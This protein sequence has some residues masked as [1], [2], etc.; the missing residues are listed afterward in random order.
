MLAHDR[1]RGDQHK[2]V[3]DEPPDVVA[4]FVLSPLER[5]GP[6]VEQRWQPKL[7]HWLRPDVE[8]MGL[9]FH[10]YGLPLV[11]AQTGEVAVVSPVE[12]FAALVRAFAG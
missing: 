10:E 1:L 6:E 2:G 9:L 7:N 3:L 11:I 12:E 8:P 5:V 4:G